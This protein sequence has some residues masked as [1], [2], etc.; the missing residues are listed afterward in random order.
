MGLPSPAAAGVIISLII[1]HQQTLPDLSDK[2]TAVYAVCESIIMYALP[3]L[4]L[5]V[6][7]LMVSRIRYPHVLNQY[8]K[9]RKPFAQFIRVLLLLAFAWWELPAA[10]VVVFCSFA[11]SS[12]AKRLYY[13]LI[14]KNPLLQAAPTLEADK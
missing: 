7:I 5:G 4:S 8:I 9:G 14:K 12:V 10:L 13:R 1:F 2:T 3:F 11:A 6:A